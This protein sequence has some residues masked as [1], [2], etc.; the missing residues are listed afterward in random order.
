MITPFGRVIDSI[1]ILVQLVLEPGDKN[2]MKDH[3]E[4]WESNDNHSWRE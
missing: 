1:A 3:P 2:P 4:K